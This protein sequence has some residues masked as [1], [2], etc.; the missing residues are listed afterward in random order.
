MENSFY[1][2]E[3]IFRHQRQTSRVLER[4]VERQANSNNA[5][6]KLFVLCIQTLEGNNRVEL[7]K[8]K[9]LLGNVMRS[10]MQQNSGHLTHT[11]GTRVGWE[12][13]RRGALRKGLTPSQT[14]CTGVKEAQVGL[15]LTEAQLFVCCP[16][17]LI[18]PLRLV[19]SVG[20][21]HPAARFVPGGAVIQKGSCARSRSAPSAL[22]GAVPSLPSG[23]LPTLSRPRRKATTAQ[24]LPRCSKARPGTRWRDRGAQPA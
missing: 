21:I 12:Q 14:H 5:Q 11:F 19:P 15:I 6:V 8:T 1:S 2:N 17:L 9:H 20:F 7:W 24:Q 22:R 13:M 16:L 23:G 10:I 18:W 4:N 3:G